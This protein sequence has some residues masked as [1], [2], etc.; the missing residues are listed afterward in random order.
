MKKTLLF[1]L[2]TS[3]PM[4]M[5]AG[6]FQVNLQGNKQTGMGHLGTALTQGASNVYFN[7]GSMTFLENDFSSELGASFILSEVA[8]QDQSTGVTERTDNPLG[9][10]FY[11][12]GNYKINEKLAA[13]LAVYTPFGSTIDWGENW[14]GKE[15][16]QDIK[17]QAIFIQ[18]TI[19]YKL[20]EKLGFGA[21]L[22][23]VL[24]SVELNRNIGGPVGNNNT[25]NLEGS[26]TAYG[27]NTGLYFQ[28]TED[29]SIG[30]TY[31]SQVDVE[32][33]EG[34]ATFD[35]HPAVRALGVDDTKFSAT[36]PLPATTTLGFGY[37][38]NDKLLVS[39]EGSFVQWSAYESL[40]FDFEDNSPALTDSENPRNYEDAV[41]IRVGAQYAAT[42]KLDVRAGFYYDQSPVQDEYFSPE[43]PNSDNLGFTTGA[44]FEANDNFGIDVSLLFIV[45]TERESSYPVGTNGS[46]GGKY[47]SRS[48]IPGIGL[49]YNF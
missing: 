34:D 36:L 1:P 13:G 5:F 44:S 21:G 14:S 4:L 7:P 29:L 26:T 39:L 48:F 9:T 38:V 2:L 23:V 45:G 30:L 32:L 28:A 49:H 42:E 33:E 11:V 43:T 40:D 3:V 18:P 25:V 22:N 15:Q 47:A 10:P 20:T 35:V 27:F 37:K 24:G 19:S 8:F 17:L 41:I 16:I 6:G 12:Y 46:F 31:R